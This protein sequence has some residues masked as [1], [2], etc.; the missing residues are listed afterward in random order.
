MRWLICFLFNT[1]ASGFLFAANATPEASDNFK[2]TS[3]NISSE[4]K[5]T[6]DIAEQQNNEETYDICCLA[7]LLSRFY[8]FNLRCENEEFILEPYAQTSGRNLDKIFRAG[9]LDDLFLNYLQ[10]E[11]SEPAI[12]KYNDCCG[13]ATYE[14]H[15]EKRKKIKD[16]SFQEQ[17]DLLAFKLLTGLLKKGGSYFLSKQGEQFLFYNR[18]K[19]KKKILIPEKVMNLVQGGCGA[20][21][22]QNGFEFL[23]VPCRHPD[24]SLHRQI[25]LRCIAL[26]AQAEPRRRDYGFISL[27]KPCTSNEFEFD[28]YG[29]VGIGTTPLEAIK[30]Y[31][32]LPEAPSEITQVKS[33]SDHPLY[34]NF[35]Y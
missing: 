21:W 18:G 20:F 5:C 28:D 32:S 12:F 24:S 26:H 8:N 13:L 34:H 31:L 16:A 6:K 33:F 35:C 7:T 23:A 3:P 11:P 25:S 22:S 2:N 27:T 1:F 9:S 30:N 4:Q 14:H 17:D 15:A 19:G 10:N 29:D